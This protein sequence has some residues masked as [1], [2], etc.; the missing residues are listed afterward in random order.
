MLL[1]SIRADGLPAFSPDDRRIA[2]LS[3][4]TGAPEL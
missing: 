4:R 3:D 2:F 1:E